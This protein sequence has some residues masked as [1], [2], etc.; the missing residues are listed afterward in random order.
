MRRLTYWTDWHKSNPLAGNCLWVK[1]AV[2][3]TAR[4]EAE[5]LELLGIPPP[6]HSQRIE[7]Y[8]F[9]KIL[10]SDMDPEVIKAILLN[11]FAY[12]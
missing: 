1:R 12:S 9:V 3:S 2:S 5:T 11:N 10:P 6:P 8:M 4:D 7:S